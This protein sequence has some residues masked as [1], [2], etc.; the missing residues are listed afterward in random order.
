MSTPA[1]DRAMDDAIVVARHREDV[2]VGN[3]II[4]HSRASRWI[5]W[6]VAVTFFLC[7]FT[8]MPIW[9]PVFG[10][11]A[12]LFGGLSVCRVLHPWFGIAFSIAIIAMFFYWLGDMHLLPSE[13]GWLGPK[14]FEYMRYQSDDTD[15][16][17]YNGGQKLYFFGVSLGMLG[18]VLSGLIMWF[19]ESFPQ[20]VR[21]L[22][23]ILHD[24]TFIVF[25]AS[26]V[27]HIYLSTAAEPGTFGSMVRGTVTR[28][29]ARLHHPAWFR[30]VTGEKD[31][32]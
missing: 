21:E 22:S 1:R 2:V 7:V 14:A 20:I 28:Q 13:R 27:G 15:V 29:W 26:I 25:A 19:P 3:E 6:S 17:K 18:L 12:P 31:R 16:G 8:G 32:R 11:M 5:H 30:E 23:Y 24:F 9:T 10:W 4:R